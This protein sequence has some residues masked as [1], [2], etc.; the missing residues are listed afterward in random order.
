MHRLLNDAK[1]I[2]QQQLVRIHPDMLNQF[3][4][5]QLAKRKYKAI[6][7]TKKVIKHLVRHYDD[8]YNRLLSGK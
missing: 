6:P 8:T 3:L 1:A 2:A 7:K 4:H 5:Y